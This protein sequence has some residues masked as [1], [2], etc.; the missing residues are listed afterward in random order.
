[1]VAHIIPRPGLRLCWSGGSSRELGELRSE[2]QDDG[3]KRVGYLS[4]DT[5]IH[6][7]TLR[8]HSLIAVEFKL[9][10]IQSTQLQCDSF[11]H[12]LSQHTHTCFVFTFFSTSTPPRPSS[13]LSRSPVRAW[14]PMTSSTRRSQLCCFYC[15]IQRHSLKYSR[16]QS[17]LVE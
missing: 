1:M 12:R 6:L 3:L 13:F 11:F 17:N 8:H 10:L 16:M 5:C 14:N 7:L 9:A 2:D 4:H 15:A